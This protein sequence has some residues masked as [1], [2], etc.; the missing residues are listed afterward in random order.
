[1]K[2]IELEGIEELL[3]EAK[4][5]GYRVFS[6]EKLTSYFYFVSGSSIGYCEYTR[7]EGRRFGTV[8][9]PST[10]NGIG[11]HAESFEEALQY[12]PAWAGPNPRGVVKYKSLEEFRKN[13]W[14]PLVER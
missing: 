5:K 10:A 11:F 6:P 13:H 2:N 12:A 9:K 4:S 8:H 7:V 3:K 14:Q 1:M